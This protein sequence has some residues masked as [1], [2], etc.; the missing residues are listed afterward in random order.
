MHSLFIGER[1]YDPSFDFHL[2]IIL[3]WSPI[4][5]LFSFSA[6][7][8]QVMDLIL[9]IC[10]FSKKLAWATEPGLWELRL[11]PRQLSALDTDC[12]LPREFSY[13]HDWLTLVS[14]SHYHDWLTLM[15]HCHIISVRCPAPPVSVMSC[16]YFPVICRQRVMWTRVDTR[17]DEIKMIFWC[18]GFPPHK[19]YPGTRLFHEDLTMR[20]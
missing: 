14:L 16:H 9:C 20:W 17:I 2:Q 8:C 4:S 10:C 6:A 19:C 1:I 15:S 7:R 13:R 18:E 3:R 11:K 5:D 12:R